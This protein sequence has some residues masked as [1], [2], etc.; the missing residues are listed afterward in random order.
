MINKEV[1]PEILASHVKL[2]D[3]A[4]NTYMT[5]STEE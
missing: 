2:V 5:S 1:D 4:Y 3:E